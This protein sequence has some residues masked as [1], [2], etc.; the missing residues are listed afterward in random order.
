MSYRL[1]ALVVLFVLCISLKL[2]AQIPSDSVKTPPESSPLPLTFGVYGTLHVPLG[3][4]ADFVSAAAGLGIVGEYLVVSIPGF[5]ISARL[6]GA[7]VFPAVN[8][9]DSYWTCS[10]LAGVFYRIPLTVNFSVQGELS[11]GAFMHKVD[12]STYIDPAIQTAVA[13]R[14]QSGACSFE[15]AP[16]YTALIEKSGALNLIGVRAGAF[17]SLK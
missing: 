15:L 14:W 2:S 4:Y 8:E 5:G 9:I 10:T 7:S 1:S 16:L 13:L 6:E 11:G 3:S 12:T 17:Y